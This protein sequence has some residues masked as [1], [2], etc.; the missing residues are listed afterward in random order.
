MR[1]GNVCQGLI[2]AF[3]LLSPILQ[4]DNRLVLD[5]D[6]ELS[7]QNRKPGILKGVYYPLE[8]QSLLD[9]QQYSLLL[10][11]G[12]FF[13]FY[14]SFNSKDELEKVR[15]AY[16]P[17]PI[18]T[19]DTADSLREAA[20]GAAERED[21]MLFEHLYNWTEWL[22]LKKAVPS[23]T[24]HIRFDYDRD[25][26]SHCPA[27]IQFSGVQEF[28]IPADFV[29]LPLAFVQL[30]ESMLSDEVSARLG[31]VTFERNNYLG[32][33]R[34]EGLIGLCHAQG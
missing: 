14:Y 19:R 26:K 5:R 16:F 13:Q 2:N 4:I 12:S 24:S 30:C 32:L 10:S 29:P 28:R 25:V 33:K 7:W 3:E 9:R 20:D 21:D 15:L 17:C 1:F 18:S 6:K 22:E 27:H 23:N 8:Y 11:D 31:N 34:P